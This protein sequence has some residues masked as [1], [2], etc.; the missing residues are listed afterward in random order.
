MIKHHPSCT[1]DY[2]EKP[3]GER[4][5]SV[6]DIRIDMNQVVRTCDDCGAFELVTIEDD[7]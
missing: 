4:P 5:Q 3:E 1:A 2:P 6:T 7:Q